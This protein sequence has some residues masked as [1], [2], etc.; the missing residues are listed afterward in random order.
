MILEDLKGL[1]TTAESSQRV[2][3][4]KKILE[5]IPSFM[6]LKLIGHVFKIVNN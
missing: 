4:L 3:E 1:Q 5:A 6:L 2:R